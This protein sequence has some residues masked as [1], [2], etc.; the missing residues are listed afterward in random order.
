MR[1]AVTA[2]FIY[3]S[4][5]YMIRRQSYLRAFPGYYAFPGGKIDADESQQSLSHPLVC[6][7]P[8]QQIHALCREI[9]EELDFDLTEAIERG[10]VQDLTKV[11]VAVTPPF[12]RYR[13][14]AHHFRITLKKRPDF[15]PHQDEIAW[16]GWLQLPVA[17]GQFQSGRVLM[18]I[19]TQN[20]LSALM[21]NPVV[22]VIEPFNLIY[23]HEQELPLVEL[24]KGIELIPVPSATLPPAQN[25]NTLR[26]GD[27]GSTRFLVD[28]TPKSDRYLEQL[29]T[30][31]ERYPVDAILISHHHPD[32]HQQ[33]PEIARALQLPVYLTGTTE[34]RLKTVY[35][36]NYFEGVD[37][38]YL[39]QGDKICSWLGRDVICHE[40]PGHDDG[41]IGLAADDMSWFF[42]ADLIQPGTTVV[43]PEPEGDMAAYYESLERVIESAPDV[44][45]PSH[46]MPMGGVHWLEQTL[47]HRKEREQA[48]DQLHRV[49]K[50]MDQILAAIYPDITP[51][52]A[53]L[54]EQNIR[55]HLRK[56]GV[57]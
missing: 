32:H 39:K 23:D 52:L 45:I 28:P 46:G 24:I 8:P 3:E 56:L 40:L 30:T 27:E 2:V 38:H 34:R 53:P 15:S 50:S 13:F 51:Q 31:L 19:P 26:L 55:Q 29:L 43:I 54:A 49:G 21:D 35:G 44:V 48:I 42:V 7:F 10:E 6:D 57:C 9:M 17:W 47:S 11:G 4:E 20:I 25:T 5:I 22:D 18:V 36:E 33:A 1:E 14:S 16:G 37:L 41:M 12:E